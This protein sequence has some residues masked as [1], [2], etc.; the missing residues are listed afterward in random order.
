MSDFAQTLTGLLMPADKARSDYFYLSFDLLRSARALRVRYRY[1]G[2]MSSD[3]VEGGS[4]VDIGLFDPR[5]MDFPGGAGFRGW[6]G[7][8]RDEF[9]VGLA[10]ATP[11]YLPGPLPAGEYRII[12][13]LYRIATEGTACTVEVEA[14]WEEGSEP[15][16]PPAMNRR[17][18]ASGIWVYGDTEVSDN[19]VQP[20]RRYTDGT[21]VFFAVFLIFVLVSVPP[22]LRGSPRLRLP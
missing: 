11:G 13:G 7:S 17:D 14:D 8:R 21:E 20:V 6:S 22:C 4:V 16:R 9:M 10:E 12:L 2:A 5:G 3:Q 19:E 1:T 15:S 18:F